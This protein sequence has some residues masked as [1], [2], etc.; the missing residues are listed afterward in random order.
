VGTDS[1]EQLD[2]L[3]RATFFADEAEGADV[4][5]SADAPEGG[6]GLREQMKSEL[7][8]RL[9]EGRP[10]RVYLGVDPTAES[11]HIGHLVPVL[12]LRQF[13]DLGHQVVFLIGDYTGLIGDPSG[14]MEARQALDSEALS[15]MAAGYEAQVFKILDPERTE[16]RRNSEWL[17]GLRLK[18]IIRLA[19]QFPLKQIVARR[20]FKQRMDR[21]ES[22]R[23]HEA[24]YALMQGYDAYALECDVQVGGYDQHFNLLAG[25]VIQA[26]FG[27]KPHVM[28]TLPLLPGTDGRK[29]SKTYANAVDVTDTPEDMYGKVMRISD[30]LIPVYL[31]LA[32]LLSPEET[33]RLMEELCQEHVNPMDIKKRL[34]F[35]VTKLYHGPDSAE[36]G[37]QTF[38]RLSQQRQIPEADKIPELIVPDELADGKTPWPAV[39]AELKLAQSRGAAKRLIEGGGFKVNGQ[40]VRDRDAPYE[41]QARTLV[42]VGKRS[43][44]YL[45][46]PD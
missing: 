41:P 20:D 30:Q 26:H 27:Q 43:F 15:R 29:M 1:K 40:P 16:V 7:G 3:M 35:E 22:L 37:Q 45:I 23:F 4:A 13:Q 34:A 39:L 10:L 8:E 19:S 31:D 38:E 33:D 6:G 18:D 11:L 42:Q 32:C 24:L 44:A 2:I 21:G 46:R 5:V 9:K 36:E 12:K 25:R 14:R 28:I 17:S